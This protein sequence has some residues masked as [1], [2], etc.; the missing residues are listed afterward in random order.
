[1]VKKLPFSLFLVGMLLSLCSCS[2]G[3]IEA[4]TSSFP[5]IVLTESIEPSEVFFSLKD[6]QS[7]SHIS[8][9]ITIEVG[10]RFKVVLGANP[11]VGFQWQENVGIDNKS[12][13]R[14]I[15]HKS[16]ASATGVLGSP[17]QDV[18]T[19]ETLKKGTT[20]ISIECSRPWKDRDLEIIKITITTK[21]E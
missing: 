11:T 8:T 20:T 10:E 2:G 15:E 1:M 7:Q 5:T 21:V 17:I 9:T 4:E 3:A 14:Q 18:W 19:F 6:F 13:V 12:I 16:V